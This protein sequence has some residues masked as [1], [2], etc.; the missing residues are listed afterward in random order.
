M[1]TPFASGAQTC[2]ERYHNPS[3]FAAT[4]ITGEDVAPLGTPDEIIA[5]LK[6]LEAAGV[7]NVLLVDATGSNHALRVSTSRVCVR[8]DDLLAEAGQRRFEIGPERRH[9]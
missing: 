3:G 8:L 5:K 9:R 6:R 7:E 1:R 4:D 2:V